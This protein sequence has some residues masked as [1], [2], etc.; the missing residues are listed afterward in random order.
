MVNHEVRQAGDRVA[1]SLRGDLDWSGRLR[2]EPILEGALEPG[3]REFTVDL[4]NVTFIDSSGVSLL[5]EVCERA[6]SEGI[7]FS[8]LRPEA[9][10]FRVFEVLGLDAVLP[11]SNASK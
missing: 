4:T 5:L 8:I 2:I 1:V 10:V 6:R 9:R 3:P 11:F 7:D